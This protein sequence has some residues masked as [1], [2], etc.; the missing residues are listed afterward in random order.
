MYE[1][2]S[3]SWYDSL[4]LENYQNHIASLKI[5][6]QEDV[7]KMLN[8]RTAE[9]E[10]KYDSMLDQKD[11]KIKLLKHDKT[12]YDNASQRSVKEAY[13]NGKAQGVREFKD[14]WNLEV[15]TEEYSVL[16]TKS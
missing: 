11:N 1:N 12:L 8:E 5:Y 7:D 2:K 14:H 4:F 9:L 16:R 3:I 6:T 13:E 15:V 10:I